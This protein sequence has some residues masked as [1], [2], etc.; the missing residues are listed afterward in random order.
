MIL[1]LRP[2]TEYILQ[3]E[4]IFDDFDE[5][6][7]FSDSYLSSLKTMLRL[8]VLLYLEICLKNP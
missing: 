4:F 1:V 8:G 6:V 5:R 2:D 3:D 7:F